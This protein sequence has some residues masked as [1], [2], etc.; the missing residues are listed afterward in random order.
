[1][2]KASVSVIE[3][4]EEKHQMKISMIIESEINGK[5][6]RNLE[7]KEKAQWKYMKMESWNVRR[8]MK[9]RKWKINIIDNRNRRKKISAKEI[10]NQC[11]NKSISKWKK[12]A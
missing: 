6:K 12:K 7:K 10:S 1:M 3:K 11:E 5:R 2:L 8:K 9:W 4:R